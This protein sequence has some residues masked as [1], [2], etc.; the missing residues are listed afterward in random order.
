VA[1]LNAAIA[2]DVGEVRDE[3][4]DRVALVH[5]TGRNGSPFILAALADGIG[6]MKQGAECAALTLATFI[7]TV[8]YE[9]QQTADTREWLKRASYQADRAVYARQAGEGGS[10]LAAILFPK[11]R[12]AVWLNVGDSRVY[13][14]AQ[15][16][17]TQLSKDDTLE[18]QLGKPIEGGRRSE[19][20][21]FIG[22]GEGLEP[23]IESVPSDL[24][25]TLL[26]TTDGVHFI[27]AD[28]LGKVVHFAQ[29]L[30]VCARRFMELSKMLGGPDNASVV[31]LS[32]E[33]LSGAPIPRVDSAYEVWD[34]FGELHVIFDHNRRY[35]PA[36]PLHPPRNIMKEAESLLLTGDTK[37]IASGRAEYVDSPPPEPAPSDAAVRDK[38]PKQKS[39]SSR[40]AKGKDAKGDDKRKVEGEVP[41]LFI[42]FP[43]KAP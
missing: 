34:P 8:I 36:A 10:T 1:P 16:K 26:L 32:I 3:N 30:G 14:S 19:L 28:Y 41:Q 21:Q 23:H 4:Q 15:A 7:D 2:S 27:D 18:G 43:L 37:Q 6:G 12:P 39:K 11:G 13:H 35:T 33:A 40:K 24:T 17:M 29:D 9:A 25:G 38:P 22:I 5:G 20:L 42:E 31:A